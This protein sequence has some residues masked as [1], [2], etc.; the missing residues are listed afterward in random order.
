LFHHQ[1]EGQCLWMRLVQ[2]RASSAGLS[3]G[4][5]LRPDVAS[6][7]DTAMRDAVMELAG[8]LGAPL[9]RVIQAG[10]KRLRPALTLAIAAMGGRTADDPGVLA[11]AAAVELLHCAT[12]VHDDLIDGAPERRGV[13]TLSAREGP[14]AAVVGGDLL[15]AA[16]SMMAGQVSQEAGLLVAR[17]LASLCRG[18]VLQDQLRYDAAAPVDRLMEVARLKTGSLFQLACLLGAQTF[19]CGPAFRE[20]VAGFGMDLGVCVQLVDD[21]LDLVS[22]PS[23]AGKP[24]GADFSSGTVTVPIALALRDCPELRLLLRP[25]LGT[26]ALERAMRL[27]QDGAGSLAEA[28]ATARLIAD[29]A[30]SRLRAVAPGQG[31]AELLAGLPVMYLDSQLQAKTGDRHRWLAAPMVSAAS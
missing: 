5:A 12:L 28:T 8:P 31:T 30:G 13:P 22:S 10:G 14:A 9:T 24:V 23:L 26:A 6:R 1:D 25:G 20:A 11:L 27:L 2:E 15:I 19:D 29:G 21:L 16:A 4:W 3:T 17:T 18:E 7:L